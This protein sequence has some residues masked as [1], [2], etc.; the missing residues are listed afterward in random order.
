MGII[1]KIF[2]KMITFY[3]KKMSGYDAIDAYFLMPQI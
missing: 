2:A 3:P 1:T